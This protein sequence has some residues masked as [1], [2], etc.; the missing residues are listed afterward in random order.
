MLASPDQQESTA[1]YQLNCSYRRPKPER[2]TISTEP[3]LSP[4]ALPQLAGAIVAGKA[5]HQDLKNNGVRA[6]LNIC[7]LDTK[8][9][10][11]NQS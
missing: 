11:N 6:A 2:P 1:L 7:G 10:G 4:E 3:D 5:G 9:P 8:N